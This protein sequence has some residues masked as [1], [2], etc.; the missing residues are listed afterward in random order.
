MKRIIVLSLFLLLCFNAIAQTQP[1]DCANAITICGNGSFSSNASGIGNVQEVNAC[2]GSEH[3]S[4]WLKINIAQAGTLGFDL[5]PNDPALTADYDFWVFP[6]NATCGSLGSPIRC[7]TTAPSLVVPTPT[8]N[9]TGMKGT[10]LSTSV[11]PGANG[12]GYVFWL[13]VLPGQSYYIAIDRPGGD[14]GFQLNWTGSATLGTGAFPQ[15]PTANNLGEVRTCSNNP[16]VG[17]FDLGALKSQINPDLV[18]KTINFYNTQANAIDGVSQLGNIISNISNPQQIFAKVTD[19]ITGCFTVTDFN[20][21]VYPVPNVDVSASSSNVCPGD[22]VIFTF[23]GTPNA[24]FNYSV[25]GAAN[26]T[27]V[28]NAAGTFTISQPVLANTTY[29]L[30]NASIINSG[31]V[32]VCSQALTDSVTV[33]VNI[34]TPLQFSSNTP[35]C[36]G[37]DGIITLTGP[38]NAVVTYTINGTPGTQNITL[39]AAG[40][41][42]ITIPALISNTNFNIISVTDTAAP[43]C[44]EIINTPGTIVVNSL[45]QV[46]APQP[47]HICASGL[48]IFDLDT[49]N[50]VIS[51]GNTAYIVTYHLTSGD[52]ALGIGA[53][54]SPYQSISG[55]QTVYVR[56]KSSATSNCINFTTLDIIT[57]PAP[58]VSP[59]TPL[60]ACANNFDGFSFFNLTTAGNE[61]LNG[62]TGLTITYHLTEIGADFGTTPITTDVTNFQNTVAYTQTVWASVIQ[63]GTTTNCRTVVPIQLIV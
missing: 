16:N 1:N 53:I 23:T 58:V 20:L 57:R 47:M 4:I 35:I 9:H 2:G 11:G 28:L 14:G 34:M 25:D 51:G 22:N 8:N 56:V 17:I 30:S 48:G 61:I 44:S 15:P 19:N 6:A 3:N 37:Q 55:N 42:T 13:N 5:I 31:G 60:E 18:N 38:A 10:I 12:N 62:Q 41:N 49:N 21:V 52:A 26:E 43:F 36:V 29:T 27:A 63:S 45:P 24:T 59:A 39:D 50:A 46:T 54:S 33:T 40:T 7:A 32:V